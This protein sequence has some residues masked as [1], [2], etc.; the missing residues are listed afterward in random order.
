NGAEIPVA[1]PMF[2]LSHAAQTYLE[3][4]RGRRALVESIGTSAVTGYGSSYD[5]V[6]ALSSASGGGSS[7][8]VNVSDIKLQKEKE[9]RLQKRVSAGGR[10]AKTPIPER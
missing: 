1:P 4:K 5:G 3:I 10:L 9:A 2:P 7:S 6:S 8:A